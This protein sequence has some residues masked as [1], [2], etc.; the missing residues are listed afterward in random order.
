[1][2]AVPL[3][4]VSVTT[5]SDLVDGDG[6]GAAGADVARAVGLGRGDR[7][8]AVG[9]NAVVGVKV[10]A[11]AEHATVPLCVLAPVI[12]IDTVVLTP[13]AVVHAPPTL[14][15]VV[16]VLSGKVRVAPLTRVIVTTGA[17]V[18]IGDRLGAA[19]ARVGGGVGL[20]GRD[21]VAAARGQRARERVGPRAGGARCGAVL[22]A[23]PGDR[24]RDDRG[25]AGS[26]A[27]GAAHGRGGDVDRERERAGGAVD[28]R[29]R[30]DRRG[31]VD[32]EALR[33][34]GAGVRGG[35][36]LRGGDANRHRRSRARWWG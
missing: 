22:G 30:D 25:V 1:M 7:V 35:V 13:A 2:R 20:R 11:L 3:T 10:H 28:A 36:G 16:F 17:L 6:L 12:E 29:E 26:G 14:V 8:D 27:A 18:W 15:T 24:E 32:G 23:R 9:R 31:A 5:G 21:R 4:V 19:R 33:A 34:R